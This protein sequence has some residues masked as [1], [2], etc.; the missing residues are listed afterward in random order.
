MKED[1]ELEIA[2][3][4]QVLNYL[5]VGRWN[6]GWGCF[7]HKGLGGPPTPEG[8]GYAESKKDAEE[9]SHGWLEVRG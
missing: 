6:I 1:A 8:G 3:I 4:G 9:F 7:V 2:P 5:W